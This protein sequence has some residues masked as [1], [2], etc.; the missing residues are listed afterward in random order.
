MVG[1]EG[2]SLAEL[3]IPW[4]LCLDCLPV[5]IH[6]MMWGQLTV[7]QGPCAHTVPHMIHEV[8]AGRAWRHKLRR[9]GVTG[10]ATL[11]FSFRPLF[12]FC[13]L[14]LL[15]VVAV[16]I[17]LVPAEL[18]LVAVLA[19]AIF[20]IA[21]VL[22]LITKVLLL[23]A[24]V[25]LLAAEVQFLA[26]RV[27]LLAARVLLLAARVLLLATKVLKGAVILAVVLVTGVLPTEVLLADVI[28]K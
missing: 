23:A 20:S 1:Q 22:L 18:L 24:G 13:L 25:L 12:L 4:W 27:L 3:F 16:V 8:W 10:P 2:T 9:H 14:V 26:A 5:C 11:N 28:W 6:H 19:I 7:S 15:V 21:I 17:I